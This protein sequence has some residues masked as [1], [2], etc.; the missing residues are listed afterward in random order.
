MKRFLVLALAVAL[1]GSTAFATDINVWVVSDG[2]NEI[3]VNPGDPVTYTV[4]GELTDSTNEG[5]ALIGFTLSFDGGDLA[6]AGEPTSGNMTAFVEPDGIN[7]PAG[8]GGTVIGGDLV[9]IGGGQNTIKNTAD[10]APFPTGA[11][12]T[13]V[14]W[15][16]SPQVLVTGSLTAP[17]VEGNYTLAVSAV[18]A[19]VIM[20]G[21]TGEPPQDFWKTEEAGVGTTA[22]LTIHA[23]GG[24]TIASSDP[25]N[26][27]ID[28]RQTSNPD[29]SNPDGWDAIE[30]TLSCTTA[31]MTPADFVVEVESGTPPTIVNV[32]VEGNT[33]T[34]ELSG[35]IP[36]GQWTCFS[37]ASDPSQEACLGYLPADADGDR[38]AA[39][40]D[41]LRVI[42][43]L[44][45]VATCEV[46]QSDIDRDGTPAPADIL[47][48]ID[49][50]N[51]ADQLDEWLNVTIGVCPSG[52][53]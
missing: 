33:A 47:R 8:Y 49:L 40:A 31:G 45:G 51:G 37:L 20:E 30:L 28:A 29:G 2:N 19:N 53:E 12:T 6:Q 9:Q 48:V 35:P 27:A 10:N 24:C 42:D 46:W 23:N 18:F 21:E 52:P 44:N 22:N 15:P 1:C 32:T 50:L 5:L 4:M 25:P 39:P 17:A 43:C 11:V 34:I 16:D 36:A 26:C 13:G 7:N 14:A 3:T 41:V 38:T